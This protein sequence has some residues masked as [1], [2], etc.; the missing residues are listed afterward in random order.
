MKSIVASGARRST[1]MQYRCWAPY[2]V[3]MTDERPPKKLNRE[4]CIAADY[5]KRCAPVPPFRLRPCQFPRSYGTNIPQTRVHSRSRFHTVRHR[6]NP[7]HPYVG[8]RSMQEVAESLSTFPRWQQLGLQRKNSSSAQVSLLNLTEA[9]VLSGLSEDVIV[10]SVNVCLTSLCLRDA[11]IDRR[12]RLFLRSESVSLVH[13]F[14]V[15]YA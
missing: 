2:R 7:Q 8:F 10:C 9:P 6:R 11:C 4:T 1:P 3:H 12:S 5:L 14:G 15:A 13:H